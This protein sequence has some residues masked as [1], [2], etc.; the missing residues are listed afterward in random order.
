[1]HECTLPVGTVERLPYLEHRYEDIFMK[2]AIWHMCTLT[3]KLAAQV[4][5]T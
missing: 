4:C 2:N 5:G 3:K 1:M